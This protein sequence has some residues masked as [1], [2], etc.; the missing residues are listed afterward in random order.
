MAKHLTSFFYDHKK[1]EID[2][3][4][5]IGKQITK[6]LNRY[7]IQ[8]EEVEVLSFI[9]SNKKPN[10][11]LLEYEVFTRNSTVIHSINL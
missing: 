1:L 5:R 10:I 2:L 8:Y 3:Y 4:I 11:Y 6:H 7:I 9:R